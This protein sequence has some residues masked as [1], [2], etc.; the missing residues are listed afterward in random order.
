MVNALVLIRQYLLTQ[1]TVTNLLGTNKDG[2]VYAAPD[3]PEHYDA[4]KG[5]CVQLFRMGGTTHP[6]ITE[7]VEPIVHIRVWA[8]QQKYKLASDVYGAVHDVLHGANEIT[9]SSGTIISA[10]EATGPTELTDPD[11]SWVMINSSYQV[12]ARPN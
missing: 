12:M 5:A 1:A 2:S 3:L 7:L 9:L 11:S 8:D 4:A 6:E 10:I